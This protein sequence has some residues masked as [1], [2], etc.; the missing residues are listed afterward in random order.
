[1]WS[2]LSWENIKKLKIAFTRPSQQ[3]LNKIFSPKGGETHRQLASPMSVMSNNPKPF[4]ESEN[5]LEEEE[6]LKWFQ[7]LG[8]FKIL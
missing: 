5:E 4:D 2:N 8:F 1:M 3:N 6:K 7:P